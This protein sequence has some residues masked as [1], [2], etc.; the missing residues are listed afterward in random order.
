MEMAKIRPP[1]IQTPEQITIKF[2]MIDFVN[3]TNMYT[4]I[5]YKSAF[6]LCLKYT[7]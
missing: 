2:S 4:K 6:L 5:L 7:S 3:E 1:K